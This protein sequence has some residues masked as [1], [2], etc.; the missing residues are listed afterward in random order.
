MEVKKGMLF[1]FKDVK[2]Y[3]HDTIEYNNS[4][5]LIGIEYDN[6]RDLEVFA[7]K[8]NGDKFMVKVENDN[9]TI[10]TILFSSLK[11]EVV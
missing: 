5:Y 4:N 1:D 6:P 9:S 2:Y 10:K 3:V 8:I 7:Y 11:R